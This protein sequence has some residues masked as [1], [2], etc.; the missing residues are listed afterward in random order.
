ETRKAFATDALDGGLARLAK[1]GSDG[2]SAGG[3]QGDTAEA[4]AQRLLVSPPTDPRAVLA[5]FDIATSA[6]LEGT[7]KKARAAQPE[8]DRLTI[9]ERADALAALSGSLQ[10]ARA[11][12][13]G[14]L[15]AETGLTLLS[16]QRE[17]RSALQRLHHLLGLA[18]QADEAAQLIKL[19][20]RASGTW[21]RR[22][23]GVVGVITPVT[24]PLVAVVEGVCAALLA[25]NAAV[26]APAAQAHATAAAF[27]DL[28]RSSD[29]PTGLTRRSPGDR[30]RSARR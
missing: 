14:L 16:A 9:G 4:A 8:W 19:G 5:G 20:E 12:L 21:A 29:A 3:E 26:L 2:A 11:D 7:L 10:S 23:R 27:A 30:S 6:E 13:V 28:V 18:R 17:W 24:S 15:V 22:G 1:H 25:G